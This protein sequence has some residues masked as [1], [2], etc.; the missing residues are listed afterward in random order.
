M[1]CMLR[2]SSNV[3]MAGFHRVKGEKVNEGAVVVVDE[4]LAFP[5]H[6]VRPPTLRVSCR[7]LNFCPTI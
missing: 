2:S 5:L 6:S 1:C 4:K 3:W 7:R